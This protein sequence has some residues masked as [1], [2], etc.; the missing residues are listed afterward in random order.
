VSQR[1]L[2]Q[3]VGVSHTLLNRSEVGVRMPPDA[4]EVRRIAAALGVG[5]DDVDRLLAAA[6]F[7]PAALEELGPGDRTLRLMARA[8][9]DRRL[10]PAARDGL[11]AAVAA[12]VEAVLLAGGAD[13]EKRG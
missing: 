5:D 3:A 11:R 4:A 8:L 2:G 9:T 1:A 12:V 7:W 6:G 13:P 10:S